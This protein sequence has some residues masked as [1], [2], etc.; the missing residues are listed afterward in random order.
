MSA[1]VPGPTPAPTTRQMVT[2]GTASTVGF[3]FDLFDLFILLYV[4]STV[5]PLFF[6]TDSPTLTLAATFASFGVSLVMRPLGGAVFGRY[7]DRH[8]RKQTMLVTVGGV[9]LATAVMG[10][11]PTYA[12]IGVAAPV[13][14]VAL[15]L[16]QGLFVGG[17]VASTHTMGTE[18]VPQR[19]RG[20]VSGLV[21]G[22]GPG[23][24]AV[25][26]SLVFLAV[27]AM[28]PGPAF[29]EWGWRVMFFTGLLASLAS[30]AFFRLLEES[31]V[32]AAAARARAAGTAPEQPARGRD[33]LTAVRPRTLVA[34][35]ALVIGAG[36]QYYLTSGYLPTFLD[37][38]NQLPTGARGLLLVWTSLAILP[39]ALLAGHASERFGRRPVFLVTGVVN[40]VALPL[41][42]LAMG[43][44][45][46][47]DT[48][49]LLG[50]GLLITVLANA[51]IAAVPIF[52]N[53]LFPTRLRATATA[54]IWNGGFAV[55]GLT[56][57]F[58]SLASPTVPDIPG[59][60]AVFLAAVVALFL[61]GAAFAPETRGALD[62]EDPSDA[63][64]APSPT[65]AADRPEA[66]P[67]GLR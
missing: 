45:G 67:G 8:G 43:G 25:I 46:P 23:L 49:A 21:A 40:L 12:T 39:I 18:T 9:G 51:P 53:E 55:G 34:A 22:G 20:L 62:R 58:V 5:G 7:A 29:D 13:V 15:R 35:A 16:V 26:A 59:R 56:T 36:A 64:P 24:G 50:Y 14:F 42:A 47:D 60:L 41:L 3:A 33:L 61:L 65:A 63:A 48:G 31:P 10:A 17:V 1:A 4:A 44:L 19:W 30:L 2:A 37:K 28:F 32:W 66:L 27:S 52:L 57:T 54:L 38:I 11:L 6:P